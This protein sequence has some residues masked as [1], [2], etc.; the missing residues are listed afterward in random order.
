MMKGIKNGNT[1][2]T[3]AYKF[4]REKKSTRYMEYKFLQ[5]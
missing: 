5:D 2:Q 1:G 3:Q 4:K